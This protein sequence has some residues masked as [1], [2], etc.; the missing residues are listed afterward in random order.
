MEQK[1]IKTEQMLETLRNEPDTEQ[2]YCHHLGGILRS[3][4]W[5][6]YDPKKKEFGDS[7]DWFGYTW[8]SED[9]FMNIHADEWWMREV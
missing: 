5:L 3:T 6:K 2:Q 9:E 4:H 8:Y 7:S 1:W